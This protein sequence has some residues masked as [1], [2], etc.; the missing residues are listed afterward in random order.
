VVKNGLPYPLEGV[1]ATFYLAGGDNPGAKEIAQSAFLPLD[2][3]PAN[4][5]LPLSAYFPPETARQIAE[6][7]QFRSQVQSALRS[8]DDGRYLRSHV[9]NLKAAISTD[10]LYAEISLDLLL[11]QPD[12][13]AKRAWLAAT[14]YDAAGNVVGI[15]RWEYTEANPIATGQRLAVRLNVYSISGEISRVEAVGELR[16]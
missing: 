5:S 16:P 12:S 3:L 6:P 1:A 7:F 13:Q 14:A 4:G 8:A 15:R 10:G 11:D 9:E 2:V